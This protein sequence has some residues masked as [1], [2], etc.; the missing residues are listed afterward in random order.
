MKKGLV[1]LSTPAVSNATFVE[2][3]DADVVTG[4]DIKALQTTHGELE[5]GAL[6]YFSDS[7]SDGS[8]KTGTIKIELADDTYTFGF[9]K[10]TGAA[11][12]GIVDKKIYNNG[13][14]LSAGDDKYKVVTNPVDGEKYVVGSSGTIVTGT[15]KYKNADDIYI[16]A[17]GGKYVDSFSDSADAD[18]CVKA[19]KAGA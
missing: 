18:E 17:N 6:H 8:M 3:L 4:D 15:S 9:T 14:L 16:V 10:T 12:H 1:L 2:A 19:L 13:I 7:Q 11:K 5:A